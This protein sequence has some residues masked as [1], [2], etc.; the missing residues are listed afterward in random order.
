MTNN[1]ERTPMTSSETGTIPNIA[2]LIKRGFKKD[3]E[4][5]RQ[6][7]RLSRDCG[8][9]E[10]DNHLIP[11]HLIP[12]VMEVL[13]GNGIDPDQYYRKSTENAT[14]GRCEQGG[15]IYDSTRCFRPSQWLVEYMS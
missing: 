4:A 13:Q 8:I 14:R 3:G 10:E 1:A 5:V 2:S 12:R 11:R 7:H 15:A 9:L 6:L